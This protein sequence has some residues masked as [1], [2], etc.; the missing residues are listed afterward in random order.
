MILQS[1]NRSC[2]LF[3][4]PKSLSERKAQF[5]TQLCFCKNKPKAEAWNVESERLYKLP[6]RYEWFSS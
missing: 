5:S 6:P 4:A 2:D 3:R 1:Q